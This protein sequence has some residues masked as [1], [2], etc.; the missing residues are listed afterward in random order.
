MKKLSPIRIWPLGAALA[1]TC[2]PNSP[3]PAAV[4][5]PDKLKQAVSYPPLA[6]WSADT[7]DDSIPSGQSSSDFVIGRD[8]TVSH[9]GKS[10]GTIRSITDNKQAW[11]ALTQAI[12]ADKYRGKRVRL[13]GYLKTQNV[14][15]D[16]GLWLRVDEIAHTAAFDNMG[17]RPVKGTTGW[18]LYSVVLDVPD[19]A[20]ALAFG[21]LQMGQ[22]QTW[23]DDLKIETVDPSKVA[24]TMGWMGPDYTK[25]PL[26]PKNL[27]LSQKSKTAKMDVPGWETGSP[28]HWGDAITFDPSVT[29]NG[30]PAVSIN[31]GRAD[32]NI[33]LFQEIKADNYIGKRIA[34]RAYIK[35]PAN[36][37]GGAML[38]IPG[39][40]DWA[41]AQVPQYVDNGKK[42]VPDPHVWKLSE[43]VVDVP[44]WAKCIQLGVQ[45]NSK[46]QIW[47]SRPSLRVVDPK[48]V[49]ATNGNQTEQLYTKAELASY[50]LEPVD[51]NFE[52]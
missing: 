10:S 36:I 51:L 16:A 37:K 39:G 15:V 14:T 52:H 26:E 49:A 9:G 18:T 1:A 23:I 3:L 6:G 29:D 13:T 48:K 31:S 44:H 50:P 25:D 17:S 19:D 22:G 46:A 42:W 34:F 8:T 2:A 24:S 38:A 35:T 45:L 11:R 32:A 20:V 28:D 5:A 7:E 40:G 33:A 43:A 30:S 12:R 21:A 27:D 4:G 47:V 41:V